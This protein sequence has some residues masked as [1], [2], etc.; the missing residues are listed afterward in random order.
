MA[1]PNYDTELDYE[2]TETESEWPGTTA[3]E[4][5]TEE[6][7]KRIVIE[8]SPPQAED[9]RF[10]MMNNNHIEASEIHQDDI[11]A[12]MITWDSDQ[13]DSMCPMCPQT[14]RRLKRHIITNHLPYYWYGMYA[15]FHCKVNCGSQKVLEINHPDCPRLERPMG[16]WSNYMRT[17]MMMLAKFFGVNNQKELLRYYMLCSP[18]G[19]P[20]QYIIVESRCL[21]IPHFTPM[22]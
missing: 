10:V 22:K 6:E 3:S 19:T 9:L 5:E 13:A 1:E 16:T 7:D 21:I 2:D 20:L 8:R 14:S 4:D 18:S 15:C 11:G 17:A 12:E